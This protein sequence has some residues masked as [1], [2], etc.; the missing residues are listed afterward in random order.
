MTGIIAVKVPKWG[1]SMAEGTIVGWHKSAGDAVAEG[2]D[3]LDIETAKITNVAPAPGSGVLRRIIVEPGET[4][5]VGALL[6]I[7]A[8]PATPDADID[9]FVEQYNAEFAIVKQQAEEDAGLATAMI[10]TRLGP[11]RIGQ[12]GDGEGV[13][14]VFLHGFAA[15]MG[16]WAFNL[17]AFGETRTL[18]TLD[19]PGHGGSTKN[20]GDGTTTAL[21][22]AVLDVFAALGVEF[23]DLVGHSLGAAAALQ[24]AIEAPERVS[25][26]VL[27]APA[28]LPGAGVD[29][30]FLD[31][32]MTAR[33]P[34]ELR[35]VLEMLVADPERITRE[36]VD[37]VIKY[38][39]VD[40]VAEAL[41]TLRDRIV[42][43]T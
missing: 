9:A 2:D 4:L 37:D 5:P 23:A 22:R 6:G 31:G 43:G 21:A 14:V 10:D 19:L 39:R 33:R 40:G 3:L 12:R 30:Q 16:H 20:V 29:S 36:M 7:I 24:V 41:Q 13:P 15:D 25:R 34:R 28:G 17:D 26:L 32:L 42:E 38:K 35:S 27:V 8:E 1:L 18:L 11:V